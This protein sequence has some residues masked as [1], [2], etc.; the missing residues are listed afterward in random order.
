MI[1]FVSY[2]LGLAKIGRENSKNAISDDL[3]TPNF[4]NFSVCRQP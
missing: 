3:E 4:R 2:A 1:Y